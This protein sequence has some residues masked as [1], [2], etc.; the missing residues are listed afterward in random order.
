MFDGAPDD[1]LTCK[2]RR[3]LVLLVREHVVQVGRGPA[4][5]RRLNHLPGGLQP[6]DQLGGTSGG[7]AW[8]VPLFQWSQLRT[9]FAH[10]QVEI[11]DTT[12]DDM[13]YIFP[14]RAQM[15][16]DSQGEVFGREWG[17][18]SDQECLIGT[19]PLVEL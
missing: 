11:A 14:D 5:E 13:G 7:C 10:D 12:T 6:T 15:W 9:P 3:L 2:A 18:R 19:P 1:R 17:N 8:Y 4:D 16:S